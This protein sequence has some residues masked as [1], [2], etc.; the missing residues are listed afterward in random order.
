MLNPAQLHPSI[1]PPPLR[2]LTF[3]PISHPL[4]FT[5]GWDRGGADGI[6]NAMLFTTAVFTW[7]LEGTEAT[8][9]TNGFGLHSFA[10][11][12]AKLAQNFVFLT[13]VVW[14]MLAIVESSV[15]DLN[16]LVVVIELPADLLGNCRLGV[17]GLDITPQH[18]I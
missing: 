18:V 15:I 12:K 5:S 16:L 3:S 2:R 11:I 8:T 1:S 9:H 7:K 10:Y 17:Q 6:A 14:E 13:F 4:S